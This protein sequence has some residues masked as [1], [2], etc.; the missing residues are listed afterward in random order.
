MLLVT[1]IGTEISIT[2]NVTVGTG[3]LH[4]ET[5]ADGLFAHCI[6]LRIDTGREKSCMT[7]SWGKTCGYALK[8]R[9]FVLLSLVRAIGITTG[10]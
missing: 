10:K 6:T 9:I 1:F 3:A 8:K 7:R 2:S 4:R 5:R